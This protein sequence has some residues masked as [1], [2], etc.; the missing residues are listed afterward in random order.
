MH[1]IILLSEKTKCKINYVYQTF[2]LCCNIME[3]IPPPEKRKLES[4]R[5][6]LTEEQVHE[7]D[8][9]MK[10]VAETHPEISSYM[11]ELAIDFCIR[12]PEEATRVRETQEWE[13]IES[14]HSPENLAKKFS[15][16]INE[17]RSIEP[18]HIH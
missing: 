15:Q 11:A 8:R 18:E 6:G 9:L 17:P 7:K 5:I 10:L 3:P 12:N 4:Y 14:M 16:Y 1:K 13:G 2:F